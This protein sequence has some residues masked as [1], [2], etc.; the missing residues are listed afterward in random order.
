MR[1]VQALMSP[2]TAYQSRATCCKRHALLLCKQ[3][4][5]SSIGALSLE[6]Q[7]VFDMHMRPYCKNF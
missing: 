5:T 4:A 7:A 2:R 1:G 6:S 3:R